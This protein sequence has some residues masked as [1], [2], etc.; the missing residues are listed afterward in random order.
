MEWIMS[1]RKLHESIDAAR[2]YTAKWGIPWGTISRITR[3]R[4]SWWP[5]SAVQ[6][7]N[8]TVETDSG[9]V[10]V[11][12]WCPD[13]TVSRFEYYPRD[14]KAWMLPLW[15]AFPEYTS[16]SMGWRMAYGEGYKYRWHHW[17]RG[18][19]PSARDEYKKRFPPPDNE[20]LGWHGF[21]EDI[22]ERPSSGTLG[23]EIGGR[24]P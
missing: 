5:L 9:I 14:P 20:E 8:F 22:A 10:E 13:Q 24:V 16:V 17:Y 4:S 19:S 6:R 7:Y 15:A 23:D 11:P 18:L 1:D 12:V 21:Y 3:E 2:A